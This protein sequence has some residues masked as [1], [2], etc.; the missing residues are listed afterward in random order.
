MLQSTA[1]TYHFHLGQLSYG[2]ISIQGWLMLSG[3]L[4]CAIV[5]IILD[6]MLW[7]T[8]N[9]DFTFSV[10]WQDML[11]ALFG[12]IAFVA[13]GGCIFVLRFLYA[14]HAGYHKSMMTLVGNSSLVVRDLS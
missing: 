12:F 3:F 11:M 9:H 5:A 7:G 1:D 8:Y 2:R 14:L 4:A 10:K 6:G 13:C